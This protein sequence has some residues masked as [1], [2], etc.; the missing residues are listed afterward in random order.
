MEDR[1]NEQ[2]SFGSNDWWKLVKRFTSCKGESNSEIPPIEEN[3]KTIY[4]PAEK[5][6]LFNEYFVKQSQIVGKDD[7]VPDM[8]P[9]GTSAPLLQI[10]PELVSNVIT[11]LDSNKAT[12]P[13]GV[14]NKMLIKAVNVLSEP[15]SIL[16]NRSLEECKFPN[17]LKK[18]HV[19]PI[20]K[21]GDKHLCANYRQVSLLSC[22]GKMLERCVQMHIFNS[23]TT[24]N[25][26]TISQ[27]G[28]ILKAS[29][30]FQL[31][32]IYDDFCKA[33]DDQSTTQA[34]FCDV[35]K[36]FD[37]VWHKGIIRKLYAMGIQGKLLDWFKDY[38][39]DRSQAVV[40]KGASSHYLSVTSGAPQGSVLGPLLFL[41]YVNDI[42]FDIES[43]IK[44]FADDTSIYLSLDSAERRT[45]ILNSDMLK[46]TEWAKKWKVAFNPLT[47]KLM[48]LSNKRTTETL[49]LIFGNTDLT[50]SQT[51][52]HLG[53][54]L[55]NNCNWE[56]HIHS[57]IAK[58][59]TQVA[60][61]KSFKYKLSR[62]SLEILYTSY[63]LPHFDYADSLWDNVTTNLSDELEKSNLDAIR[64]IIGA[65]RGTSHHKLYEESGIL[66]LKERRRRH[67]LV[68]YFRNT[69]GLTPTYLNEYLP[70]LVAEVNPYHRRNPLERYVPRSRTE[71]YKQSFFPSSIFNSLVECTSRQH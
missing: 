13:D 28:F 15:L 42:V 53:V 12:G 71:L 54:I 7:N 68:T 33:L 24:N 26:L 1:I 11:N 17:E 19:T 29:T 16:F 2:N 20:Y 25:L 64:T 56:S 18:A 38:L 8:L 31:L 59:R 3:G 67:K 10:T 35:S 49:P 34:I 23:L 36:A 50:E 46:I 6:Q 21:K 47:T 63:V 69:K 61:L 43:T 45:A 22:I 48:T 39:S 58:T 60:C 5:A 27:S 62:K 32:A 65:V 30:T 66:P 51:H 52:K 70:P 40:I 57:V 37:R 55:Q 44:L 9:N 14:H 4:L 41:I